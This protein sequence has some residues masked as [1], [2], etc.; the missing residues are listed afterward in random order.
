MN[1]NIDFHDQYKNLEQLL[2]WYVKDVLVKL[3]SYVITNTD[4]K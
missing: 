4:F 2:I 1:A 3:T